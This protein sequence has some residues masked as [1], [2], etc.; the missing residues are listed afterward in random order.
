MA[1]AQETSPRLGLVSSAAAALGGG[2]HPWN[3]RGTA[4]GRR[5]EMAVACGSQY[6]YIHT[7]KYKYKSKYKYIYIYT[8]VRT[9]IHTYIHAKGGHTGE[10]RN[11]YFSGL[12]NQ[13][14]AKSVVACILL[15]KVLARRGITWK[16]RTKNPT[17]PSL[18][19]LLPLQR[20]TQLLA[21]LQSM[22]L[23]PSV[24]VQYLLEPAW[25]FMIL[26]QLKSARK[27][28]CADAKLS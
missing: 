9:Y 25:L 3:P 19:Q 18:L 16:H 23:L 1:L 27:D 14:R 13:C 21:R 4:P 11:C 2:V 8:Y 22:E 5:M 20:A 12:Q 6:A 26:C 10:A 15:G 24:S 28:V 7:Y 17:C